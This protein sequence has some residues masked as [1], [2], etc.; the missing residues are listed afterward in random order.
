MTCPPLCSYPHGS[1]TKTPDYSSVSTY[2]ALSYIA[3]AFTLSK[4]MLQVKQKFGVKPLAV[5]SLLIPRHQE[6]EARIKEGMLIMGMRPSVFWLGWAVTALVSSLYVS[7]LVIISGSF[8]APPS[9]IR[10]I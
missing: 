2:L 10:A 7:I 1:G 8:L 4:Q 5:F 3:Y 6:K 9:F